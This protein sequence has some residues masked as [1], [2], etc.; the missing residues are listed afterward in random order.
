MTER[1]CFSE[2][3]GWAL[4]PV[5]FLS[6]QC[7]TNPTPKVCITLVLLEGRWTARDVFAVPGKIILNESKV[8]LAEKCKMTA[9]AESRP[10]TPPPPRPGPTRLNPEG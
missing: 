1:Y 9:G 3:R 4:E 7:P 10:G 2:Q 8:R 5:F 6:P